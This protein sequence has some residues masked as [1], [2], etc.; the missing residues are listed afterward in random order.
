MLTFKLDEE[1]FR[2]WQE[3]AIINEDELY[4]DK[5]GFMNEFVSKDSFLVHFEDNSVSI[6][7]LAFFEKTLDLLPVSR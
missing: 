6:E 5:T 1:Q 3:F 4:R 7:V 2:S